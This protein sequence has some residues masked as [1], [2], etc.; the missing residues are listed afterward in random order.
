VKS[1]SESKGPWDYFRLFETV[2][3]DKAFKT[4]EEGGCT[5]ATK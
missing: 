1:P 2:S 4:L 3:G 5:M